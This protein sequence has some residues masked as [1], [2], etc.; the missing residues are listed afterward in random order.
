MNKSIINRKALVFYKGLRIV[1][2][3]GYW[4]NKAHFIYYPTIGFSRQYVSI[5]KYCV[6]KIFKCHHPDT[7]YLYVMRDYKIY[8]CKD[9]EKLI[10]QYIGKNKPNIFKELIDEFK[11]HRILRNNGTIDS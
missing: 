2:L 11:I 7:I 6:L 3:E 8:K 1:F 4:N 10:F 9:C 5:P